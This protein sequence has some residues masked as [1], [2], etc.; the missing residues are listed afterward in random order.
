MDVEEKLKKFTDL[1]FDE[2]KKEQRDILNK[3]TKEHNKTCTDYYNNTKRKFNQRF[4]EEENR[5]IRETQKEVVLAQ[6]DMKRE[7]IS[8]RNS[9]EK[10]IFA[11]VLNRIKEYMKTEEYVLSLISG[12]NKNKSPNYASTVYLMANDILHK[13][14]IQNATGVDCVESREDFI[15]GFKISI[16]ENRIFDC[17]FETR[18]SEIRENF[19]KIKI[20]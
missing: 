14:R 7:L 20:N 1:V 9:Q 15:G 19:N 11:N 18:L 2:A 5:F 10:A 6:T 17:S 12:I 8:L 16:S 4:E 3:I 13:E